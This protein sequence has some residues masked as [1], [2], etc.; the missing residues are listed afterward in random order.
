VKV[1][2]RVGKWSYGIDLNGQGDRFDNA[3]NSE[4]LAGYGVV[5]AYVH[6]RLTPDWR[7]EMRANNVLDKQYELAKGYA[8]AG[9]S[10]FVGLRYAPR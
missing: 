10:Y 8:T 5:D 9:A 1:D 3:S 4:R 6:Y 2:H 7:V